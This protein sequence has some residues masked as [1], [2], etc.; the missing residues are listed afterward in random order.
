ML[1]FGWL[2][3]GLAGLF[4][5]SA[6]LSMGQKPGTYVSPLGALTF[7]LTGNVTSSPWPFGQVS[8]SGVG[9]DIAEAA[10]SPITGGLSDIASDLNPV[11]DVKKAF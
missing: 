11:N 6:V 1:V 3:F 4:A 7:M 9:K 8:L 5:A 2:L 10:V